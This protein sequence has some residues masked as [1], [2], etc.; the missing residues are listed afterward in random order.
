MAKAKKTEENTKTNPSTTQ[1]DAKG[2]N[3]NAEENGETKGEDR[4]Q[5]DNISESDAEMDSKDE[6]PPAP[7]KR[8]SKKFQAVADE[9]FAKHDL[10]V[11]FVT[12]DLAGFGERRYA[13]NHAASLKDK[14]IVEIHKQTVIVEDEE[15]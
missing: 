1:E 12:S 10:D 8:V 5:G 6:T 14:E 7:T 11:V 15:D 13:E 4:T 9:V 3:Q 2:H